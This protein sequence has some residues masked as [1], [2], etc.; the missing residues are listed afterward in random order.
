VRLALLGVTGYQA[1]F[2]C[3][4][5]W[6]DLEGRQSAGCG[7]GSCG[8]RAAATPRYPPSRPASELARLRVAA[9]LP[10]HSGALCGGPFPDA[11]T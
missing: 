10:D 7:S 3:P 4:V 5:P 6:C 2:A 8:T 9:G 1:A 11:R